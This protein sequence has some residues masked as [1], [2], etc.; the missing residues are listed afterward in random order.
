LAERSSTLAA[1]EDELRRREA[2]LDADLELREDKLE[3][4][5]EEVAERERRLTDREQDLASFVGELQQQ[6]A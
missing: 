1:T 5:A 4:L 3:R 6:I 2:R